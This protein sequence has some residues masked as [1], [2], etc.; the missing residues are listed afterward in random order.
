M[1]DLIFAI[2]D[3]INGWVMFDPATGYSIQ[4]HEDAAWFDCRVHGNR[5]CGS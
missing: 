4:P 5:I 3:L 1:L 2:A